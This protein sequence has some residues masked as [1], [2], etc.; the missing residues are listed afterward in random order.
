MKRKQKDSFENLFFFTDQ[1]F[2]S[3]IRYE[4]LSPKEPKKGFIFGLFVPQLAGEQQITLKDVKGHDILN[5]Y[6][7]THT[8]TFNQFTQAKDIKNFKV[9]KNLGSRILDV[10]PY[11]I[12]G[13]AGFQVLYNEGDPCLSDPMRNYQ[14]HVKYQCAPDSHTDIQDYPMLVNSSENYQGAN[15]CV[16]DFIWKSRFACS[17]CTRDQVILHSSRCDENGFA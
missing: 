13:R 14:S 9:L 8:S 3:S 7:S 11:Y 12:K 6:A 2:F 10:R 1:E 17:P 4:Y 5:S 15:E 16:F